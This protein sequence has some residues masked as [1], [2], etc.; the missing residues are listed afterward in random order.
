[1]LA[2][3]GAP[4]ADPGTEGGD[5]AELRKKKKVW[6]IRKAEKKQ[7]YPPT[8]DNP[9]MSGGFKKGNKL[10]LVKIIITIRRITI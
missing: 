6:R 7:L 1:M 8:A 5:L 9:D 3:A 2:A 4:P 10:K